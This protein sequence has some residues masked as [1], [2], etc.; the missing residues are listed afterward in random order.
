MKTNTPIQ[1][2]FSLDLKAR[3]HKIIKYAFTTSIGVK[4][5]T[6]IVAMQINHVKANSFTNA[7]V[8]TKL[9]LSLNVNLFAPARKTRLSMEE[10]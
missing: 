2:L 4:K 1:I 7:L 10:V 8:F 6:T 5:T 9:P 3:K